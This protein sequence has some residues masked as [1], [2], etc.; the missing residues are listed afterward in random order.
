[1]KLKISVRNLKEIADLLNTIVS[2][3]KFS[4]KKDGVIIKAV[5]P[6]HVAMVSLEI[7]PGTFDNYEIDPEEDISLDIERLKSILKLASSSDAISIVKEK[8]RLKF[9]IGTI[10]KTLSLLDNNTISTPRVP[11][12]SS[13]SFVVL[14]KYELEK[15]LKAAEDV[16]DSIRLTLSSNDFRARSLSDTEESEMVL[17]RELLK[18]IKCE[19]SVKSSYPLDYL[20]KLVKSLSSTD[21]LKL[22]FKDDYPLTIDF[23]F[24]QPAKGSSDSYIKGIFLLAPRMEQ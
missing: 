4:F 13:E 12:V 1:M 20:L 15:G 18:E 17:S 21:T 19:E 6:A 3:A 7:P 8:D 24:G 22:S 2:E 23:E 5:D 10:V 11:Q 16:S 14:A 9:E